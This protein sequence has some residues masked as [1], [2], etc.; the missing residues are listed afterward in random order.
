[1]KSLKKYKNMA[2]CRLQGNQRN[3]S[4]KEE[5]ANPNQN[6][7]YFT[8][9]DKVVFVNNLKNLCFYLSKHRNL[10]NVIR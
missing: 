5:Y 4:L 2:G 9:N 1:M 8:L 6:V 10:G 7:F 3:C